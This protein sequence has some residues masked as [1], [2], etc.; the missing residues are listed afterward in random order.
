MFSNIWK[1]KETPMAVDSTYHFVAPRLYFQEKW[2]MKFYFKKQSTCPDI[3]FY[4]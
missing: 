4:N 3:V 1:L 2:F